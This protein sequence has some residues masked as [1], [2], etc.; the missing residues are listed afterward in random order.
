[1]SAVERT[2]F[3]MNW[4]VAGMAGAYPG[5][6]LSSSVGPE[7]LME[8]FAWDYEGANRGEDLALHDGTTLKLVE[9][10]RGPM[11]LRM[12]NEFMFPNSWRIAPV[13]AIPLPNGLSLHGLY[14]GMILTILGS[15]LGAQS[16]K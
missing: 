3:F 13:S 14:M 11:M 6:G 9:V 7:C 8:I 15:V 5:I 16:S 1:M 10:D 4:H 12:D 2:D